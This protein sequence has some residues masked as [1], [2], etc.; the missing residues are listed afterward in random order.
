MQWV[1]LLVFCLDSKIQVCMS[2]YYLSYETC[3]AFFCYIKA[4][5]RLSCCKASVFMGKRAQRSFCL[6]GLKRERD[7]SC[8][9]HSPTNTNCPWTRKRDSICPLHKS[10]RSVL[11]LQRRVAGRGCRPWMNIHFHFSLVKGVHHRWEEVTTVWLWSQSSGQTMFT[12]FQHITPPAHG[13]LH[14]CIY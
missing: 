8:C 2:K 12:F 6:K 13:F 7:Q 10:I 3:C 4:K 14:T 11:W 9:S 5:D 1:Y